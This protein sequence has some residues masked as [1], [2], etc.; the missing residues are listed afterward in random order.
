MSL[1]QLSQERLEQMIHLACSYKQD[2]IIK[3]TPWYQRAFQPLREKSAGFTYGLG[4]VALSLSCAGAFWLV[5][6]MPGTQE[7]NNSD[8]SV[9]EYMMQDLLDDLTQ[10]APNPDISFQA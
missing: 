2:D 8:F 4:A 3:V 7:N 6:G 10:P 9:S 5:S 1:P